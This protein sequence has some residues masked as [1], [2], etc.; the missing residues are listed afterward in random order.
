M[1]DH[2]QKMLNLYHFMLETIMVCFIITARGRSSGDG[3]VAF[4][5][6]IRSLNNLLQSLHQKFLVVGLCFF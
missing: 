1:V 3:M 2:L 6:C 5:Q 4:S